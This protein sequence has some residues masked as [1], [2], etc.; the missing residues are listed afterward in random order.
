MS[1]ASTACSQSKGVANRIT[2]VGL[3]ALAH[4]SCV[5]VPH[6]VQMSGIY[7]GNRGM[8][9]NPGAIMRARHALGTITLIIEVPLGAFGV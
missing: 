3:G 4:L 5:Y 6:A 7:R 2:V 9:R 1:N 8:K